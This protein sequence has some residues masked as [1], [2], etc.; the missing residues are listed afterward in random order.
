MG[1]SHLTLWSLILPPPRGAQH[2]LGDTIHRFCAQFCG[3]KIS[4]ENQT[5]V[6]RIT[7]SLLRE[8]RLH[9]CCRDADAAA[10]ATLAFVRSFAK[11]DFALAS[12]ASL[13]RTS[14][15]MLCPGGRAS[16]PR[17]YLPPRRS[18]DNLQKGRPCSTDGVLT[19]VL[20][21]K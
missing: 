15:C 6:A 21:N 2:S 16:P 3:A 7:V 9:Y 12:L 13:L 8:L 4:K 14:E 11:D 19:R 17:S 5:K 1:H 18:E 20:T 10:A